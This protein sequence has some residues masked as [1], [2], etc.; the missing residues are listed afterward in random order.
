MNYFHTL[1]YQRR[2][3]KNTYLSFFCS[4][5]QIYAFFGV[6]QT[7]LKCANG[8]PNLILRTGTSGTYVTFLGQHQ[9]MSLEFCKYCK[10]QKNILISQNYSSLKI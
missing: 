5:C 8:G 9:N 7:D 2:E 10:C 6:D 4:I 1:V 3:I